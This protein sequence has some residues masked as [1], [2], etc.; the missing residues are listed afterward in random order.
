MTYTAYDRMSAAEI[1]SFLEGFPAWL[2]RQMAEAKKE[3]EDYG[4]FID[5]LTNAISEWEDYTKD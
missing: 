1:T 5:F 2:I 3:H 4:N